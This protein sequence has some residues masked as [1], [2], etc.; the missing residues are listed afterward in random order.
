V[1]VKMARYYHPALLDKE[2]I[3]RTRHYNPSAVGC[4]RTDEDAV[5][6]AQFKKTVKWFM[7]NSSRVGL[8]EKLEEDDRVIKNP[9]WTALLEAL[10]SSDGT[11][12]EYLKC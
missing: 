9:E 5:A 10:A 7:E 2:E 3:D 1:R 4:Y 11:T 6:L 8:A 12:G